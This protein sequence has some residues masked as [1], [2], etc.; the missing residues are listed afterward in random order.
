MKHFGIDVSK[1]QKG[2]DF[3]KAKSEGVEFVIIK[4]SQS[5]F[6]D[7]EFENHFKKAKACGLNVGAYHY[8]KAKNKAEA[9]AEAETFIGAV[10]GKKFEFPLFLDIE[11]ANQKG[12]SKD[13]NDGIITAFCTAVENAGYWCGFYCNYDFYKNR[14]NGDTLSERF[15]LWLA[16]WTSE[17]PCKCQMWQFGGEVN[18]LRSELVAGVTCDQDSTDTDYPSLIAAKGLNGYPEAEQVIEVYKVQKGDTLTQ[19]AKLFGT[20]VQ[21]LA[22]INGI[23]NPNVIFIGQELVLN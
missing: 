2:F 4:A 7:S 8:L 20:T 9:L 14:C 1:W 11:D 12:N 13:I 18:I 5:D 10:K 22:E 15:S 6:K 3:A 17:C 19:I 21:K 16:S 23:K